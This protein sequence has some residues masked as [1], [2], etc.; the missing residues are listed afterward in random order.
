MKAAAPAAT[1]ADSISIAGIA[2]IAGLA[3]WA[4]AVAFLAVWRVR[5]H[6]AARRIARSGSPARPELIALVAAVARRLGLRRAPDVRISDES[7]VP[8][9]VGLRRPI[10]VVPAALAD[11]PIND[12]SAV[13]GHEL[14]H[15]RRRDAWL[16]LVQVVAG[17]LF[18]F[19]PVVRWAS[20]R[21]DD[22][23]ELAC[24]AWAIA[25]GPLAAPEYARVLV[26]T[27]RLAAA[28][29]PAAALGLAAH[30]HF[31]ARRVEALLAG[32]GRRPPRAGVGV[33]G[34]ALLAVWVVVS[35]GGA[36]RADTRT[37]PKLGKRSADCMFT[38]ELAAE[39]LATHPE[40][41]LD[42]DGNLTRNEACDFQLEWALLS[43]ELPAA[44]VCGEVEDRCTQ[45]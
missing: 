45:E 14:A 40:A 12:L 39:I 26:R 41:D 28:P 24:D 20:R 19:W 32:H 30:P 16:R 15:L 27:A 1:A 3:L 34:V 43:T 8:W 9:V 44:M 13:V 35:L 7:A 25:R 38:P 2:A 11:G 29:A 31:L 42:G 5:A 6:V 17:T 37:A 33:G 36:A 4:V 18:F 23:R 22:A 10:L 21:V